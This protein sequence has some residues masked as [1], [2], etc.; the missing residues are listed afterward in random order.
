MNDQE[1]VEAYCTFLVEKG[2]PGANHKVYNEI[3]AWIQEAYRAK[4]L[5]F[6]K[7]GIRPTEYIL[8]DVISRVNEALWSEL[9]QKSSYRFDAALRTYVWRITEYKMIDVKRREV[10]WL[11]HTQEEDAMQRGGAKIEESEVERQDFVDPD[12]TPEELTIHRERIS[13]VERLI[14]EL[15][16][17]D[18]KLK[19][20]VFYEHKRHKQIAMEIGCTPGNIKTRVYRNSK[21]VRELLRRKYNV[22]LD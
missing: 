13:M 5:I 9:C 20:S 16:E 21:T 17:E 1:R 8:R 10:D 4:S 14:A 2:K 15:D 11:K 19:K 7:V 6:K 12:P 18:Q 22:T 3:L